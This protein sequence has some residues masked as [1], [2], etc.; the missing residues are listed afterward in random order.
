MLIKKFIVAMKRATIILIKVES[1]N[2]LLR[3]PLLCIRNYPKSVHRHTFL[4]LDTHHPD[5][6]FT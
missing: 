3:M 4:I 1:R 2:V 5:K 6:M